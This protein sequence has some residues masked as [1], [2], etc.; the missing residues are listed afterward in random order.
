M[1]KRIVS[2]FLSV[3]TLCMALAPASAMAAAPASENY[4]DIEVPLALT[5]SSPLTGTGAGKLNGIFKPSQTETTTSMGTW[6]WRSKT[7]PAGATITKVEVAS[8]VTK[9]PG[10][11]YYVEVGRGETANSIVWAPDISWASTVKTD[12]FNHKSPCA[13]WGV[14][15]YATRIITG[16]DYGAGATGSNVTLRVYFA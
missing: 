10:V 9:V 1:K 5:A 6:D 4:V 14:R 13:V 11:T 7:V 15:F 16:P 2:L 8:S 12:H 3:L